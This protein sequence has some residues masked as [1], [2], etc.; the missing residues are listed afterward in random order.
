MRR[1]N[2]NRYDSGDERKGESDAGPTSLRSLVDDFRRGDP[3]TVAE[4]RRRVERIIAFSGFRISR[5]D[6]EELRQEVLAQLWQGVNRDGFDRD[7]G[8]WGFVQTVASRRCIDWMRAQRRPESMEVESVVDTRK[9][10]LRRV[11]DR[12]REQDLARTL[13]RLP[14]GCRDLID[15]RIVQDKSYRDIAR[16]LGRSEQALRAQMYRCVRKARELVEDSKEQ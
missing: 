1:R 11:L 16:Q 9:S 15:L 12:E 14:S 4:V 5:P 13:D 8:F 10:P 3:G 6:Q 7:R 2:S